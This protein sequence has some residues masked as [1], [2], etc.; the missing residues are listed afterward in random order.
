[1]HTSIHYHVRFGF[2]DTREYVVCN[3]I[4][5]ILLNVYSLLNAI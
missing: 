1:M 4:G 3:I 2:S 5:A